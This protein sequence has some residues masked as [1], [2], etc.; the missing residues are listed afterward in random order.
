MVMV[1]QAG[2]ASDH[3]DPSRRDEEPDRQW[4]HDSGECDYCRAARAAEAF[5]V[6]AF[7]EIPD[8]GTSVWLPGRVPGRVMG[9]EIV[10][11]VEVQGG[12]YGPWAVGAFRPSE[13]TPRE[14]P[15]FYTDREGDL[16]KVTGEKTLSLCDKATG[17]VL[18]GKFACV[19]AEASV[20][21][22]YAPLTHTYPDRRTS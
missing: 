9:T 13:I 11:R 15:V 3:W 18:T 10:V 17:A 20:R 22:Q 2:D 19:L 12:E 6:P 4:Y 21:E 7:L 14:E 8:N 5:A 16:W 1:L